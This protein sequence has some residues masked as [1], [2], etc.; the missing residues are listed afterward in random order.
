MDTTFRKQFPQ[1]VF[2]PLK[3][4]LAFMLAVINQLQSFLA[5]HQRGLGP[6]V[7]CGHTPSYLR[8]HPTHL[9][10]TAAAIVQWLPYN[11]GA[12]VSPR[13]WFVIYL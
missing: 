9:H 6:C 12:C 8:H 5:G 4:P 2:A 10:T 7:R 3:L 1:R 11:T 13:V